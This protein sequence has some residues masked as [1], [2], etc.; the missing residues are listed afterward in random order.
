[1]PLLHA[2]LHLTTLLHGGGYSLLLDAFRHV[3]GY[4]THHPSALPSACPASATSR[5]VT[6]EYV[7]CVI[8]TEE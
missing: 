5:A 1:M 2:L 8:L 3:T 7:S 6:C 4:V